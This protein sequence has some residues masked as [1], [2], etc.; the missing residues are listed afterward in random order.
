MTSTPELDRVTGRET[1]GHEWDGLRELNTPLPSWW[2]YVFYACIVW[3]VVYWVAYPAIPTVVGYT[4]GVLGYNTRGEFQLEM[5][6]VA[7]GRK[8]AM[9]AIRTLPIDGVAADATLRQF[10]VGG[11]RAAFADNCAPCHGAGGQGGKGYPVL[12][13]DDWLWGGTLAEIEKTV[14]YGIRSG[15]PDA[16]INDMPRYGADSLLPPAQVNDLAELVLSLSNA[17]HDAAAAARAK[18]LFAEQCAAC[19]GASGEGMI[20][21]GGPRLNDGIW[22]YGGSK[23]AIAGQIHA[24]RQG[25]MPAWQGRLD[26]ATIKMLAIYVRSLGGGK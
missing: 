7:E 8:S 16:R 21:L 19:H 20:E 18:P 26:D 17:Q 6:R 12:A 10:A 14:R 24:P 25:V 15:H 13:D 23:Q 4:K 1:T 22:L 2:L 9:T 11:G 5:D 3:A